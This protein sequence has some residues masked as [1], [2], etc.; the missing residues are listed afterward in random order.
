M[1]T[2]RIQIA[3]FVIELLETELQPLSSTVLGVEWSGME[4]SGSVPNS[5]S[6]RRIVA[7]CG[8]VRVRPREL[9][10]ASFGG[11]RLIGAK[12]VRGGACVGPSGRYAL[13]PPLRTADATGRQTGK[14]APFLSTD[15][16]QQRG[17]R[18][19]SGSDIDE[20]AKLETPVGSPQLINALDVRCNYLPLLIHRRES[21]RE[22]ES[23]DV[24]LKAFELSDSGVKK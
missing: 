8:G 24:A 17:P 2:K 12:L 4:W 13:N 18:Q 20:I 5:S 16:S 21:E 9:L 11:G 3:S 14:K 22:W 23:C 6:T 15:Q 1:A 19:G 7:L 10:G